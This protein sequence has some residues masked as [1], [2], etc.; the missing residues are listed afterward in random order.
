MQQNPSLKVSDDKDA[1]KM[2]LLPGISGKVSRDNADP[3]DPWRNS[4]YGLFMTS[5]M[6]KDGGEFFIC[7]GSGGILLNEN[8]ERHLETRIRGTAVKVV[9][10]TSRKEKVKTLL[11]TY[12]R[13]GSGIARTLDQ[14]VIG[15][16]MTSS[17]VSSFFKKKYGKQDE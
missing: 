12:S 6:A 14:A 7:S 17:A 16:S 10:N 5:R 13:E 15:A 8:N 4:G 2:A 1:I 11:Q 9:L 3:N